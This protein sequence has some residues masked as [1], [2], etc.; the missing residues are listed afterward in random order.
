M[1]RE[2]RFHQRKE[3]VLGKVVRVIK[4]ASLSNAT[5]VVRRDM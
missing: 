5:F 3:M 4:L 1:G 2:R